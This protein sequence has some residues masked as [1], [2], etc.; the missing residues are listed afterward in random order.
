[1][2]RWLLLVRRQELDTAHATIGAC[3]G[4]GDAESMYWVARFLAAGA[5]VT[6]AGAVANRFGAHVGGMLLAFPFVISTGLVFA[7][8][9]GREHF[10]EVTYG[11]LW[12]LGPLALFSIAALV[13]VRF[14]SA[15]AALAFGVCV[16]LIV[17][18]VLW[19][20]R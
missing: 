2:P 15:Q 18:G 8:R 12:G 11:V 19:W 1:M 7:M 20:L 5:A 14:W 13:G 16:W 9:D 17:A 10:A 6:I 4:W 3:P